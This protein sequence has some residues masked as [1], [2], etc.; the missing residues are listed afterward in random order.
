MV[1]TLFKDM[2][3]KPN[4]LNEFTNERSVGVGPPRTMDNYCSE[5]DSVVLEDMSGRVTLDIHAALTANVV[6]GVVAGVVGEVAPSGEL[7]VHTLHF[8]GMAPHPTPHPG[9]QA[10]LAPLGAAAPP[11]SA[12]DTFTLLTSGLHCGGASDPLPLQLL[13]DFIRGSVGGVGDR[14][15]SARIS[16]VVVAGGLVAP[17]AGTAADEFLCAKAVPSDMQA[18]LAAPLAEAD[19]LLASWAACVALDI[20]PGQ[21]DPAN[22]T[23]PQQ[24]LHPVL[25]PMA[26]RS[27]TVTCAP[28]PL[29]Q[30]VDGLRMAGTAG[31]TV[32]NVMAY[33]TSYVPLACVE[34]EGCAALEAP[35]LPAHDPVARTSTLANM[36]YWRHL[37]PTAPDTLAA[38]PFFNT[39]PFVVTHLDAPHVLFAGNQPCYGSAL[40]TPTA[41]SFDAHTMA[42]SAAQEAHMSTLGTAGADPSAA[43]AAASAS[44]LLCATRVVAVPTF[45]TTG[46]VVLLNNRTL[47]TTPMVFR[48]SQAVPGGAV[49]T[50][51]SAALDAAATHAGVTLP[52]ETPRPRAGD[53]ALAQVKLR[54][55][56][57][58]TSAASFRTP[59]TPGTGEGTPMTAGQEDEEDEEEGEEDGGDMPED[60]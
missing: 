22:V 33:T 24:P 31:Q 42:A 53:A 41:V 23:L 47:E 29:D 37:A 52:G 10:V 21:G 9:G 51:T 58:S 27:S 28:N 25:L 6:T 5:D 20:M 14:C 48:V 16:R 45:S 3:L 54:R 19:M 50:A 56:T 34:R 59:S 35:P 46:T 44:G 12:P 60:E 49:R 55:T 13:T 57:T 26:C 8:L 32:D 30:E 38:Y 15:G 4:I 17:R 18:A 43:A 36:L 11:A 2:K 7:R 1:G 39:D 40:V